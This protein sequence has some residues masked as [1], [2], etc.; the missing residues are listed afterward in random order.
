MRIPYATPDKGGTSFIHISKPAQFAPD[1]SVTFHIEYSLDLIGCEAT[2]RT[3]GTLTI[4]GVPYPTSDAREKKVYLNTSEL[5]IGTYDITF[6]PNTFGRDPQDGGTVSGSG[7]MSVSMI[8]TKVVENPTDIEEVEPTETY[9]VT[10][11]SVGVDML[12][13]FPKD[14]QIVT[15]Q[16]VGYLDADASTKKLTLRCVVRDTAAGTQDT[17][18]INSYCI[19]LYDSYYN[20]IWNSDELMDWEKSS[21]TY[22]EYT[23]RNLPNNFNGF[24]QMRASL[25]GGYSMS[26]ESVPI[27]VS[28]APV[29]AL[30][31]RVKLTSENGQVKISMPAW[32]T[33][34]ISRSV[35]HSNEWIELTSYS[36]S[37]ALTVYDNY[38]VPGTE[39][40]YKIEGGGGT[41]YQTIKPVDNGITIADIT[42]VY[43]AIIYD[44]GYPV[45][46]NDRPGMYSPISSVKPYAIINGLQ[47]ND[48]GAVTGLFSYIDECN[49]V[50][51][52]NATCSINM[53]KWLNNGRAKVL[54][55][56]TGDAWIVT[57]TANSTEKRDDGMY[58]TSFSWE[59]IA[60]VDDVSAYARLGLV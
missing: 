24:V 47:N 51:E 8:A 60:D 19:K 31:S 17:N 40:L 28:Y 27:S 55:Y 34:K 14:F 20:L 58:N 16:N 4:D 2:F 23:L 43:H 41:H 38:A 25:A 21:L 35:L 29:P 33:V 46:R 42:G 37:G 44:N 45:T 26:T 48:H 49:P 18:A 7:A 13:K 3:Y 9:T 36:G 32:G 59:E 50:F 52:D 15:P 56:N 6:P 11:N 57:T 1:E 39:Y 54:K 30:S 53:R 12:I 5:G 10:S 22:H